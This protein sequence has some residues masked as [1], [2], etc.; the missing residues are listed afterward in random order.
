MM[1]SEIDCS[2][3]QCS[4]VFTEKDLNVDRFFSELNVLGCDLLIRSLCLVNGKNEFEAKFLEIKRSVW[5]AVKEPP[6]PCLPD[7]KKKFD[8]EYGL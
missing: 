5:D 1:K 6:L 8:S 2:V 3:M 7:P 4:R